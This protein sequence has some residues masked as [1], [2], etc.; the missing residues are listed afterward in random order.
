MKNKNFFELFAINSIKIVPQMKP[1]L[2]TVP[3][4]SHQIR[5]V[6]MAQYFLENA[7]AKY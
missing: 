7:R 4:F 1:W 6:K 5:S 2:A 3:I